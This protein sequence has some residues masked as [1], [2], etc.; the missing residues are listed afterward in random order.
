MAGEGELGFGVCAITA[1]GTST[2]NATIGSL[3]T[4]EFIL[5]LHITLSALIGISISS[6]MIN[7]RIQMRMIT[8]KTHPARIVDFLGA[9]PVLQNRQG[10]LPAI[11]VRRS[12]G[13]KP[14]AGENDPRAGIGVI[15]RHLQLFEPA[16]RKATFAGLP[17]P[18]KLRA[19][20]GM[21][22]ATETFFPKSEAIIASSLQ[23][24]NHARLDLFI[25]TAGSISKF[26][27]LD[28]A[29]QQ[30]SLI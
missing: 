30:S 21:D 14:F 29:S 6:K 5:R 25:W 24:A 2:R 3:N 1:N 16:S 23:Q 12:R 28:S 13:P 15:L 11:V 19:A 18:G 9:S 17:T 22:L 4:N 27:K 20:S 8:A 7:K 10:I 26:G